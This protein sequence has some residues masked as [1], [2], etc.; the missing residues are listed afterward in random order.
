[1]KGNVSIEWHVIVMTLIVLIYLSM[2]NDE[3][4]LLKVL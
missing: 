2:T 3:T 4:N 1:M